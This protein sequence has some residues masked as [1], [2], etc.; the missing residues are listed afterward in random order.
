MGG[1]KSISAEFAKE[2]HL[3]EL[4]IVVVNLQRSIENYLLNQIVRCHRGETRGQEKLWGFW[5]QF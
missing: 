2:D 4:V 3:A 1:E 5:I